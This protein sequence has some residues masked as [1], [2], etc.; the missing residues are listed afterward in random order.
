MDTH[1]QQG[2]IT[3][4]AVLIAGSVSL[5][6]ALSLLMTGISSSSVVLQHR[7]AAFARGSARTCA[8]GALFAI[9]ENLNVTGSGS[10]TACTYTI[11]NQ[12]GGVYKI[13]V[14]G[15]SKEVT[16]KLTVYAQLS[17]AVLSVTSWQETT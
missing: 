15:T 13:D 8:E 2:Y 17:G 4:L 11:A 3:L 10:D 5:A 6:V 7:N 12:G 16:K 14:I 9:H 1:K